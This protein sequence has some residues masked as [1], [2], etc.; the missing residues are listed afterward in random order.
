MLIR[1]TKTTNIQEQSIIS[2]HLWKDWTFQ[3][4]YCNTS[5]LQNKH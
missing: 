1:K 3:T 2:D 5:V 4:A